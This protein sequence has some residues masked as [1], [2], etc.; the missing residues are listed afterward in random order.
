MRIGCLGWGSLIWNPGVLGVEPDD[1][2][3]DGPLLPI[4][5]ARQS[6]DG[7]VTLVL[8][9]EA[10][11]VNVLWCLLPHDSLD[12]NKEFLRQREGCAP[13][14]IGCWQQSTESPRDCPKT[15][16]SWAMKKDLDAVIWTALPSKWDGIDGKVPPSFEVVR[17][18][19]TLTG[20]SAEKAEE[21]VRR[22][23]EQIRSNYR[24]AIE[25]ALGWYPSPSS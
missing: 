22:A 8:V 12:L 1:W 10:D 19:K 15:I 20:L 16:P 5:F 21:Y 17:Y 18:L 11:P 9:P 4:E 13:R 24:S 2:R 7:R 6:E 25:D 3:P 14:R 23:P